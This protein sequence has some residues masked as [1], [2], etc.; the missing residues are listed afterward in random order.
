M[1][2]ALV[3]GVANTV[4]SPSVS[5]ISPDIT[6]VA[7]F[8]CPCSVTRPRTGSAGDA[9]QDDAVCSRKLEKSLP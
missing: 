9:G 1:P 4:P 6:P 5:V 8:G 2:L 3:K 7:Q